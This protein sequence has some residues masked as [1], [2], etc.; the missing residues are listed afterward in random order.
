M[1]I[2]QR[3]IDHLTLC[4][5]MQV[6][7]GNPGFDEVCLPYK[8]LPELDFNEVS[9]ATS[10]LGF[11]LELPLIISSMTGGIHEGYL[12]N[13]KLAR[14]AQ[15]ARVAFALG[16]G[17][18]AL[19]DPDTLPMFRVKHL[20]PDVPLLANLGAVQ[21]NYGWDVARCN[22][23]VELLEADGLILHLNPLQEVLQLEGNRNFKGLLEKIG[24]LV[25]S[26]DYPIIVKEV[27]TGISGEVATMLQQIGIAYIDVAGHG[28]TNWT[29]IEALRAGEHHQGELFSQLG[30]STV[31]CLLECRDIPNIKLIASG[32]VRNGVDIA[33]SLYLG[34]SMVGMA[35]P[36]LVAED[37]LQLINQLTH[38]LKVTM[39]SMGVGAIEE[40]RAAL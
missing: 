18:V 38:E 11:N 30:L 6:Q 8:A 23:L 17:R 25:E 2:R 1:S 31:G 24:Q 34:A 32:G 3:K 4:K 27:G 35:Y 39:F 19:E 40:M 29:L 5:G 16:S 36:F 28:G 15:K 12:L 26:A 7:R 22:K 9:T 14:T 10:F 33:K 13:E 20:M 37:P 21:L